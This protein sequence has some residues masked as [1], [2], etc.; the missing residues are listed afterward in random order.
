[1]L[2]VVL[3]AIA[4]LRFV[5]SHRTLTGWADIGRLLNDDIRTALRYAEAR[6][7]TAIAALTRHAVTKGQTAIA[8][9]ATGAVLCPCLWRHCTAR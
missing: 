6:C 2:C 8:A 7:R 5:S 3:G 9:A 1:M 4:T